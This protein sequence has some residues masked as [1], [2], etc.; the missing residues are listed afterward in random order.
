MAV[1]WLVG[2]GGQLPA[3]DSF[4]AGCKHFNYVQGAK[5]MNRRIWLYSDEAFN[6]NRPHAI[7]FMMGANPCSAVNWKTYRYRIAGDIYL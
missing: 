1:K 2:G 6:A 5:W 4:I 3:D 7:S